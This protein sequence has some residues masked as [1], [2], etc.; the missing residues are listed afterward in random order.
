MLL[1]SSKALKIVGAGLILIQLISFVSCGSNQPEEEKKINEGKIEYSVTYPYY[2]DDFMKMLLPDHLVM[3]FKNNVYK[4]EITKAGL[5]TTAMIADCNTETFT[6]LLDFGSKKMY[7][8]LDKN[9]TD[10]MVKKLFKIP[11]L[12]K[13]NNFDSIAGLS[14]HKYNAV[15]KALE[16]GYD[17]DVYTSPVINIKNSNWCNQYA[18][19]DEVLLGYEVMQYGLVMRFLAT[20]VTECPINDKAFTVRAN[21]E[22]VTLDRMVY[23]MEEIFKSFIE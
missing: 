12:I 3:E 21:F 23:E 5:F 11:D 18:A 2:T 16:D 10:T 9:L 13:V 15:Y 17:C 1:T 14:T 6:M 4:N 20:T 22:E 8:V 7:C 19:L